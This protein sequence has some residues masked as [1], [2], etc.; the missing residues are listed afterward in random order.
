MKR[1]IVTSPSFAGEVYIIYG[2][3]D[4]LLCLDFRNAQLTLKQ[5]DYLRAYTPVQFGTGFVE[6][7]GEANL[8]FVH[9][10]YVITF[11]EFWQRYDRKVNRVRATQLWSRLSKADQAK[12]WAGLATY[13]RYLAA[14]PWRTKADPEKYLRAKYWENEWK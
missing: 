7:F 2:G 8:T 1:F 14:N 6:A 12:A 3:D 4:V 9:E 5:A 11:E 13:D 10:A